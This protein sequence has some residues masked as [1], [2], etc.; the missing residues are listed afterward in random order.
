MRIPFFPATSFTNDV[1]KILERECVKPEPSK[2]LSDIGLALLK[3]VS[4]HRGLTY[5]F[6]CHQRT[7][8][9]L[10]DTRPEIFDEYTRR[11][12]VAKAPHKNPFGVEEE[13]NKFSDFDLFTKLRVLAQLSQWTLLNPDRI[14]EK[15]PEARESE[16][17]EWVCSYIPISFSASWLTCL[18]LANRRVWLRQTRSLLL[19]LG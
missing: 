15:M 17:A 14:R 2:V 19:S 6:P 10:T 12:Y 7:S 9:A 1:L 5:V 13:P 11:Q 16:Q 18:I 3:F 4:S 8:L